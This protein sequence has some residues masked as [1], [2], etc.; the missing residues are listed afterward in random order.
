VLS[1][2]AHNATLAIKDEKSERKY[3][4]IGGT[5][6]N[7]MTLFGHLEI[8]E[9]DK[10]QNIAAK[11]FGNYHKDAKAYY[12]GKGPHK[13][14]WSRFVVERIYWIGGEHCFLLHNFCRLLAR[15]TDQIILSYDVWH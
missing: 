9:S 4:Q 12:P 14:L 5:D 11:V 8:I 2:S 13:A 3:H 7:R 10:E 6:R 15:R 1:S